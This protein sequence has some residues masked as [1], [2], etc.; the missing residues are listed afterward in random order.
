MPFG[1][2]LKLP[3]SEYFIPA[4]EKELNV[5]C[6]PIVLD[7][8]QTLSV[9]RLVV[10]CLLFYFL[11]KEDLIVFPFVALFTSYFYQKH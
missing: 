1:F 6:M 2:Y 5:L 7:S 3:L 4:K 9:H 11:G 8:L 10:Q